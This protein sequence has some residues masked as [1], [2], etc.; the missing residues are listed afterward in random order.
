MSWILL[1]AMLG[2][3]GGSESQRAGTAAVGASPSDA[4]PTS[5]VVAVPDTF[6]LANIGGRLLPAAEGS[7]PAD[8]CQRDLTVSE[9]VI[10]LYATGI[11]ERRRVG[12]HG[13]PSDPLVR[14]DTLLRTGQ[15]VVSGDSITLKFGGGTE[16]EI[17]LAGRLGGDT[18]VT[19]GDD[20]NRLFRHGRRPR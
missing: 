8:Q 16:V 6:A 20:K 17:E 5:G 2:G 4:T 1:A 10:V 19:F 12:R 3:C 18:I 7:L 11:Y 15:Y 9:D 14:R 13:C